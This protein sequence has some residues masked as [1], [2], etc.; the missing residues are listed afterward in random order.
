MCALIQTKYMKRSKNEEKKSDRIKI[1]R[2]IWV[3]CSAIISFTVFLS[4]CLW[5]PSV[6]FRGWVKYYIFGKFRSNVLPSVLP[7]AFSL[8]YNILFYMEENVCKLL[9]HL[10]FKLRYTQLEVWFL[11]NALNLILKYYLNSCWNQLQRKFIKNNLN[12]I[13]VLY[14]WSMF[15]YFINNI[16]FIELI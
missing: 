7:K 9:S 2:W 12:F 6:C 14:D 4:R 15:Q 10:A 1:M 16:I 8:I 11:L 5:C 3:S 13:S